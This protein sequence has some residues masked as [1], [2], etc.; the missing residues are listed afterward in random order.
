V[1]IKVEGK[2]WTIIKEYPKKRRKKDL[3]LCVDEYGIR[4][5]FQRF[6][7]EGAQDWSRKRRL[8]NLT[9]ADKEKI[10]QE[11]LKETSRNKII[12][13]FPDVAPNKIREEIGRQRKKYGI[14]TS[15]DVNGNPL[16]NPVLQYD[17]DMNFIAKYPSPYMA[18]KK[19]GE[20]ISKIR[21]ACNGNLK[22][23]T[24]I[25]RWANDQQ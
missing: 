24:F 13:M 17:Q 22:N 6:E 2:K 21:R 12:E 25:W 7:V 3:I 18:H 20:G 9:E 10:G 11:V 8:S 1:E 16:G 4:E 19:T 5:C 15:Y 14:T 23:S